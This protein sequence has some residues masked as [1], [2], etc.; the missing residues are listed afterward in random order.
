MAQRVPERIKYSPQVE[1]RTSFNSEKRCRVIKRR[2]PPVNARVIFGRVID[3]HPGSDG[4]IRAVT[5]KTATNVS[6]RCVK[7]LAVLPIKDN[8]TQTLENLET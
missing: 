4:I 5:V 7:K 1:I 2:Q 6:K 8:Y 3:T